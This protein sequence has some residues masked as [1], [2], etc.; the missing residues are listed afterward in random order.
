MSKKIL[1]ADDDR[2]FVD[3]LRERL[4]AAG[5]K[6]VYAYEG[7]RAVE[8]AHKERPDLILLDW[9]M[10]SGKGGMVLDA[11]SKKD[12]TRRIP[13]IVISGADEPSIHEKSQIFGVK[14]IFSKPYDSK[15]LLAKIK[16]ALEWKRFEESL[17]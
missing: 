2:D 15:L 17:T 8:V 4:E 10:P 1:I 7:I 6:T 9:V 11:L 5:Y 16:E 13:V 12:D 14:A 3:V